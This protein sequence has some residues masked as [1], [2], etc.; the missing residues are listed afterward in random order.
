MNSIVGTSVMNDTA[1]DP[2]IGP[3]STA[4]TARAAL[5]VGRNLRRNRYVKSIFF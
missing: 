5:D 4:A 2:Y 3:S 1:K